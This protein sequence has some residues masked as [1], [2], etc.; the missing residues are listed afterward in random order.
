MGVATWKTP[1]QPLIASSKLPSSARSAF[2]RVRCV[3]ALGKSSKCFTFF[4]LAEH[5]TVTKSINHF[6]SIKEKRKEKSE[7]VEWKRNRTWI[8]NGGPNSIAALQ[9][10]H[11]QPWTDETGGTGDAHGFTLWTHTSQKWSGEENESNKKDWKAQI[12]L[13]L[14]RRFQDYICTRFHEPISN[15]LFWPRL[16]GLV[17]WASTVVARGW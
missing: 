10:P 14:P 11:D 17:V 9:E 7:E 4:T 8:A 6:G 1:V 15:T 13:L 2:Q 3:S 12:V 5:K 16:D